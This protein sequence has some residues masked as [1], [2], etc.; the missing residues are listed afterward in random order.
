MNYKDVF[1]DLIRIRPITLEDFGY[2]LKWSM[3]DRFCS[4]NDWDINRNEQELYE[5]W[6]HC[7][8]NLPEDFIRM[9]I[10]MENKLI[11]Y[12]D[13]AYIK[14]NSAELGIAIGESTLWGKG[15]GFE[16]SILMIDYASSHFSITVFNAET[17]ETNI[18][19]RRMLER[20][21]FKEVSRIG[22]EKYLRIET[23]LI[24][25]KLASSDK[26]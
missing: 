12:A 6:I 13:L 5:W 14:D 3:D 7:V 22:A 4:A 18:R 17:H 19:A 8:N 2:V 26:N 10:E 24:Q 21:G 20:I 16:S 15:I 1:S 11:G 9:G 23:K 25:Y